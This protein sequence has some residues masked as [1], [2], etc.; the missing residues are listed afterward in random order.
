MDC[1]VQKPHSNMVLEQLLTVFFLHNLESRKYCCAPEALSQRGENKKTVSVETE[2]H[3]HRQKRGAVQ[4]CTAKIKQ[5]TIRW[6]SQTQAVMGNRRGSGPSS[7][8]QRQKISFPWG[9]VCSSHAGTGHSTAGKVLSSHPTILGLFTS[10]FLL[11]DMHHTSVPYS[12]IFH[13]LL[14]YSMQWTRPEVN[15]KWPVM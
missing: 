14:P 12:Q 4:T 8:M 13:M 1:H 9:L 5:H 10:W 6:V 15:G 11:Q 3:G 7:G 2:T